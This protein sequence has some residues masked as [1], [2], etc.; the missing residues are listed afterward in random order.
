[1]YVLLIVPA[2]PPF[3]RSFQRIPHAAAPSAPPAAASPSGASCPGDTRLLAAL[4]APSRRCTF[5]SLQARVAADVMIESVAGYRRLLAGT[6]AYSTT[7]S[8][9]GDHNYISAGFSRG[10]EVPS[11]CLGKTGEGRQRGRVGG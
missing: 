10:K 2:R 9:W 1:M 11:I 6:R 7:G 4:R 5:L 3:A 8:T